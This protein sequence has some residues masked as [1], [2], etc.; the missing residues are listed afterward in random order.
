MTMKTHQ[1]L[2]DAVKLCQEGSL[3]QYNLTSRNEK[4]IK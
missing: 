3:Y 4:N 2:W 1:N